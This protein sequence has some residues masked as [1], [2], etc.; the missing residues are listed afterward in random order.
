MASLYRTE[1]IREFIEQALDRRAGFIGRAAESKATV[2]QCK[3]ALEAAQQEKETADFEAQLH[4][5]KLRGLLAAY[6]TA[7]LKGNAEILA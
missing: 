1:Q 6:E 7:C 3:A 2:V 5:Q 4:A